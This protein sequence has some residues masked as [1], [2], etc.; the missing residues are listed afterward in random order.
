MGTV[1]QHIEQWQSNRRF[2]ALIPRQHPD[3]IVTVAFYSSLHLVDAMLH[4]DKIERVTN[5]TTRNEVLMNVTRYDSI[6]VRYHP[7][8][9]LSRTVRYTAEPLQ[10][11]P[12]AVIEKEVFG[13]YVYPIEKAAFA[14]MGQPYTFARIPLGVPTAH[15]AAS[16]PIS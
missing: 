15:P 5:H 3:W 14:L 1:A 16:A 4:S 13:R 2:L 9:N 6:W 10:W 8:Y 7:L 12:F 11:V